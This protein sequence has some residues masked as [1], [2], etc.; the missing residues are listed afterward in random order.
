MRIIPAALVAATAA[1]LLALGAGPAAAEEV[2]PDRT[3]A[4]ASSQTLSQS[5]TSSLYNRDM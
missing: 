1:A 3:I 2:T 4:V 5:G